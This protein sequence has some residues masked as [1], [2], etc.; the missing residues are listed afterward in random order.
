MP[1]PFKASAIFAAVCLLS[2]CQKAAETP[3]PLATGGA[4]SASGP[5]RITHQLHP[6][7]RLELSPGQSFFH[8]PWVSAPSTTTDRDGLGPLFNAHSCE[9]CHKALGRGQLPSRSTREHGGLLF[10]LYAGG[11]YGEQLQTRATAG[12]DAEAQIEISRHRVAATRVFADGT[13]IQL[14]KPDYRAEFDETLELS[15]RLAPP[16]VGTGLIDAIDEKVLLTFADPDDLDGDGISGQANRVNGTIG[17]FGWKA[18]QASLRSQV[19][20]AFHEDIGITSSVFPLDHSP[21]CAQAQCLENQNTTRET[22]EGPEI[23]DSGLDAVAAYLSHLSVP[24]THK[25]PEKRHAGW[26]LFQQAGC[27]AC[28]RTNIEIASHPNPLLSKQRIHPYSD[29]LLHDMGPLLAD[30][31]D[32][33]LVSE[34]RTAPLWG[35]GTV[36]GPYLHDGRAATVLEAILWHSGEAEASVRKVL[37]FNSG[38]RAALLEF[39]TAL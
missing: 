19:A 22:K 1:L 18:E 24:Q 36:G 29:F 7:E 15:P 11:A 8:K 39:L 23:S 33:A 26:A 16:L 35:L 4:L 17:R 28:H 21:D 5:I 38:E 32:A 37:K 31:S 6:G 9:S 10:R 12:L 14:H 13:T 20:K 25:R 34:W 27:A 2:A 30:Q 3:A